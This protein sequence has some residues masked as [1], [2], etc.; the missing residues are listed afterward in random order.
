M[1]LLLAIVGALVVGSGV[2]LAATIDCA[3]N[4]CLGTTGADVMNGTS[5]P[6]IIKA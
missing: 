5:S 4:T 1:V 3:S 6:N 2:A